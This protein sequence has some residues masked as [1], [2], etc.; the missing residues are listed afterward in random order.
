MWSETRATHG[1]ALKV[2]EIW[3][4]YSLKCGEHRRISIPSGT[5]ADQCKINALA[6]GCGQWCV[7]RAALVNSSNSYEFSNTKKSWKNPSVRGRMVERPWQTNE[8]KEIC[9]RKFL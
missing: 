8:I 5:Q 4:R 9:L 6:N 3:G 7:V 1:P 2:T